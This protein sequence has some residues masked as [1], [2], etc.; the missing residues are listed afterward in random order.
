MVFHENVKES[1][2]NELIEILKK[3]ISILKSR[4]FK[5][6]IYGKIFVEKT[7]HSAALYFHA[8]DTVRLNYRLLNNNVIGSIIHEL[9]HRHWYKFMTWQ[10]RLEYKNA[11]ETN[12]L[13]IGES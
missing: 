7:G 9:G 8:N 6:L 10:K 2:K 4:G 12:S 13:I 1:I 11:I 3:S 5:H